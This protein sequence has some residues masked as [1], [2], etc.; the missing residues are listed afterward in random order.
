[1]FFFEGRT[2]I[3]EFFVERIEDSSCFFMMGTKKIK[4][5]KLQKGSALL[6]Y[7]HIQSK[8]KEQIRFEVFFTAKFVLPELKFALNP[9]DTREWIDLVISHLQPR[10]DHPFDNIYFGEKLELTERK[11]TLKIP[12]STR[13]RK[14]EGILF[15]FSTF[16]STYGRI[17]LDIHVEKDP[18]CRH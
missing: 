14:H 18:C 9:A 13:M 5:L 7:K 11:S 1:M 15:Y 3:V 8:N 10:A 17:Q 2:D 4:S 16:N 6:S 12:R